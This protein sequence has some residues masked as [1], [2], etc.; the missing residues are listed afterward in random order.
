MAAKTVKLGTRMSLP[1]GQ[2]FV[3]KA[4]LLDGL[5]RC[6]PREER[7][8]ERGTSIRAQCPELMEQDLPVPSYLVNDY[9]QRMGSPLSREWLVAVRQ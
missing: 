8:V 3:A 9:L 4:A 2:A 6:V 5:R 7:T 1:N